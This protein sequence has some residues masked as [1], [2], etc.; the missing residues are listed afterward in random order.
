M[1]RTIVSIV[2]ALV[3]TGRLHGAELMVH[4]AA[5]LT[6]ALKEIA[7]VYEPTSGDKLQFN[8]EASSALEQQIEKGAPGDLFFSADEAKMDTLESKKL[9]LPGTRRTVLA[10]VLVI[11]VPTGTGRLPTSV[12]DLTNREYKQ[13]G[14]AEPASVPA[15]IYARQYL[16]KHGLWDQLREKVVPAE[17]VRAVLAAVES[18]NVEAAFIYKTDA[19]V[20]RKV[21]VAVEIPKN[22]SPK[23]SY[24][25]AVLK[26]S[27][28]PER[29]ERFAQYLAG[30][31][32][33]DIFKKFGFTAAE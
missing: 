23:I 32:A 15:G 24:P 21:R 30:A 10:N 18:G 14:L 3:M 16:E 33:R 29:A 9:L 22:D 8:F 27:E 4:A 5:S 12:T 6:D 31:A 19:L 7:R 2:M 1:R 28:Q 26:S 11:V 20:S 13:I 17:N 25:L